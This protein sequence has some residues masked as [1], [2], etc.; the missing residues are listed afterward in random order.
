[1]KDFY[2]LTGIVP[3]QTF[4]WQ[5]A[6]IG[7]SRSVKKASIFYGVS[8]NQHQLTP[9]QST[10]HSALTQGTKLKGL[11][12]LLTAPSNWSEAWY[13]LGQGDFWTAT[14][15]MRYFAGLQQWIAD[16]GIFTQ[17]GRQIFFIQMQ[18]SNTPDH[19]DQNPQQAPAGYKDPPEFLWI[20]PTVSGKQ[21]IVN[22]QQVP[23]VCWFNSYISHCTRAEA[24]LRWSLRID[25]KFTKEFKE[26]L[27]QL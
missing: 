2:D 20:T 18:N 7:M 17:T 9:E 21:L 13:K 27:T 12:I 14:E 19:V 10:W 11:D 23:T 3:M 8:D 15:N 25:G 16:S 6:V 22:K 1:M 24:G 4:P 26:K 5:E